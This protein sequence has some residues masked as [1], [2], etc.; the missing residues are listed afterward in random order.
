M[1]GRPLLSSDWLGD[2]VGQKE[3][4]MHIGM[5][6]YLALNLF[7]LGIAMEQHGKPKTGTHNFFTTLI[8]LALCLLLLYWGG[9]FNGGAK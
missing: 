1:P 2:G 6:I 8:A 9:A 7:S 3:L 4:Q 5:I